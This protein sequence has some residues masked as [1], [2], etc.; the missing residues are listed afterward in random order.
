MKVRK[1]LI[2]AL[3]CSLSIFLPSHVSAL[4]VTATGIGTG[5]TAISA[6]ANFTFTTHDFGSGNVSAVQIV[7]TNMATGT[8]V[9]G[10]LLTGFFWTWSDLNNTQ[11]TTTSAGFD[12]QAATN[13]VRLST[14]GAIQNPS[15]PKDI[16]PAVN[17]TSTDGTY[18]LNNIW[19]QTDTLDNYPTGTEN[20]QSR[21]WSAY[22][23]AIATVA[24][25][26]GG[27]NGNDL[28]AGGGQDDYGIAAASFAGNLGGGGQSIPVITGSA[29]FWIVKP[30]NL[31]SLDL[32]NFTFA[33]GSLPDNVVYTTVGKVPEPMTVILYGFGFAGAGLYR[34]MRRKLK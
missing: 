32:V 34:R 9:R 1:L 3:M 17:N 20:P 10:N 21:D 26:L 8:D 5:G 29:T 18:Q 12:G 22:D 31:G 16:A 19:Q 4:L 2:F 24:Y 25:G 23:Y 14:T 15:A 30:A 28:S 7:L 13:T 33:Y 6:S 27:F 11:L